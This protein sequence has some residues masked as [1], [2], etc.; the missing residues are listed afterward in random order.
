MKTPQFLLLTLVVFQG[1]L[2]GCQSPTKP[3]QFSEVPDY[4]LGRTGARETIAHLDV[5]GAKPGMERTAL[6][7][8]IRKAMGPASTAH[9]EQVLM[10]DAQNLADCALAGDKVTLHVPRN[11]AGGMAH[12]LEEAGLI[13]RLSE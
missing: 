5:V 2:S 4:M 6:A 1:A 7:Q 8:G 10:R 11:L 3:A 13:V 9:P 12:K